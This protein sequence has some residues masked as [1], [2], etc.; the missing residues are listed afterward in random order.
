MNNDSKRRGIEIRLSADSSTPSLTAK[1]IN[2]GTYEQKIDIH[3]KKRLGY[4]YLVLDCSASMLGHK[5]SQAKQGIIDFAKQATAKDYLTGLI[6]FDYSATHLCEPTQNISAL[7]KQLEGIRADGSTNM[8]SAIEMAHDRLKTLVSA[9][10]MVIATDG[11]PN[12]IPGSIKAGELAKRDGIDIIA[13]GTDDADQEFLK[14][15]ASRTELGSKVAPENL[16]KAIASV[17][18]YL[19]SPRR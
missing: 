16:G 13:V 5:L 12:D 9:R 8:V 1:G 17:A 19:P 11:V 4:V 18:G 7:E 10:V 6:K 14:R 15:L 2:I 3:I